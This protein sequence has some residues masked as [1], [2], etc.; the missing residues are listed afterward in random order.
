MDSSPADF[1]LSPEGQV[2]FDTA[3][4]FARDVMRPAGVELDRLA[5]PADVIAPDS[6]LWEVHA[7]YRQ[8]GVRDLG[9][10]EGLDPA[11]A[12]LLTAL[13]RALALLYGVLLLAAG[14]LKIRS[15]DFF[16]HLSAGRW[17][18]EHRTLP[19]TDPFR[20]S[21]DGA[22]WADHEWGF[23]LLVAASEK[24]G[25]LVG[26][27]LLRALVVAAMG[28]LLLGAFR[29]RG[30]RMA[31]AAPLAALVIVGTRFRFL[32]RP[33]L[34]TLL[35]LLLLL[36][37]L[38]HLRDEPSRRGVL[39]LLLLVVAW[40]NLHPGALVAPFVVLAFGIGAL[41]EGRG[42]PVPSPSLTFP[43]L[44]GFTTAT[45]LATLATPWGLE[46]WTVPR[47]ISS[48]LDQMTL[49]NPDWT[50][51]WRSP[52]PFAV[53]FLAAL[54]GLAAFRLRRGGIPDLPMALATAAL[55]PLAL[56][57]IRH[58]A[59]VALAGGLWAGSA[60]ADPEVTATARSGSG[61]STTSRER[62]LASVLLVLATLWCLLP[63]SRGPLRPR[64]GAWEAGVGE[65]SDLFPE[66]AA[67]EVR[68]SSG[69][70][71]LFNTVRFGGYL[72]YRL[73]PERQVFLDG[74][75]E[76]DTELLL[77]YDRAR[78]SRPEWRRL[79]ADHDIDGALVHY[80]MRPRPV[81][82]RPDGTVAHHTESALLFPPEDFALV[83][84]DD[85]AMLFVR[86]SPARQEDLASR[87]YRFVQPEDWRATLERASQDPDFRR[88]VRDELSRRTA[89]EP[90]SRHAEQLLEALEQLEEP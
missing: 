63:P 10:L 11:E 88:G 41:L 8:L 80:E 55:L 37:G 6:V 25:G 49:R 65:A 81:G 54:A 84:W 57:S 20:F 23:Q 59:L 90:P 47:R 39:L 28:W 73:Y 4:R 72:L 83:Y 76:V 5:D 48:V 30:L 29:S 51:L 2:I 60:L 85:L 42:R 1:E 87:E 32:L 56:S 89:E 67:E 45:A 64:F 27:G 19:R 36:T 14:L 79:L 66:A 40:S 7:K 3:H 82:Q 52:T 68:R 16:W 38:R 18:L 71:N 34:F 86:R 69:L 58:F 31:I 12:S 22:P 50:P 46:L 9:D 15:Y 21:S 44:L 17:I 33:E 13:I 62:L 74:R 43:R 26:V 77:R 24:L 75:N 78:T 53:L 35:A 61:T 70:G